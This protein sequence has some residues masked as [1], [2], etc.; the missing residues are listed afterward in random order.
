MSLLND[1]WLL[2]DHETTTV[3]LLHADHYRLNRHLWL[4][5]LNS[6]NWLNNYSS[7]LYSSSWLLIVDVRM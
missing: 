1:L 2:L 6:R 4:N 7:D 5:L 3:G